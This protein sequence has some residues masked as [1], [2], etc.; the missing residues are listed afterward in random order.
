MDIKSRKSS[1]LAK[2]VIALVVLVPAFL[3]VALYPRMESLLLERQNE[4]ETEGESDEPEYNYNKDYTPED[5]FN[6]LS[7]DE[8]I[9]SYD[10][11]NYVVESS[12]Y[13]H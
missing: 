4:V 6:Y 2:F 5:A 9:L 12:Y 11:V 3:L 13:W 7:V 1:K 10:F 8:Y